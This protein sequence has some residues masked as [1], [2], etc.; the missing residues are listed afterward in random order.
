MANTDSLFK[1]FNTKITLDIDKR[2]SLM[3]SRNS[4]RDKIFSMDVAVNPIKRENEE[5]NELFYYDM[6]YGVYF[7]G[8]EEQKDRKSIQTYHNWIMNAVE[9]HTKSQTDKNTCVRVNYADGHNIDFPIYYKIGDNKPELAHKSKG[10]IESDPKEMIEWFEEQTKGK[11][12]LKRIVRYL[13]AW[14]DYRKYCNKS[15]KMPSGLVFTVLASEK[16]CANDRDDIA[17]KDTLIL[18]QS[19]LKDKFECHC[20]ATPKDEILASRYSEED[21]FMKQLDN[22]IGDAKKAIEEKNQ[23]KASELWQKHFGDRFLLGEDKEEK[24]SALSGLKEVAR[25]N[26]PYCH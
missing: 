13:K 23:L 16:Y 12:Q 9:G 18:I 22:L 24:N 7:I 5:G 4:L 3:K 19:K 8:E 15:K 2:K 20:P 11:P 1:D 21:Y 17:F 14:A 6:D 26:K 25:P 10:W